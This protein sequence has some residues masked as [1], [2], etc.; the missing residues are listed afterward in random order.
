M[1][2]GYSSRE[3]LIHEAKSYLAYLK[4]QKDDGI[5]VTEEEIQEAQAYLDA[6]Y[7]AKENV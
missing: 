3:R 4:R 6:F 7:P 2:N 5:D 1:T